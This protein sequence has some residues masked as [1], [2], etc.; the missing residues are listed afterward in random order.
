MREIDRARV[1]ILV[2]DLLPGAAA[3]GRAEHAALRVRTIGMAERGHQHALAVARV[4]EDPP[5]LLRVGGLFCSDTGD[6][7]TDDVSGVVVAESMKL[8]EMV[9][10]SESLPELMEELDDETELSVLISG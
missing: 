10:K 6:T 9:V 5:D 3:V 8:R 1:G 7:S 2:E 4:D